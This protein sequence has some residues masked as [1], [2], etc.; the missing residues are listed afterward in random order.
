MFAIHL[1]EEFFL[2]RMYNKLP[3]IFCHGAHQG[4]D[5]LPECARYWIF[6]RWSTVWLNLFQ[7]HFHYRILSMFVC[8][9]FQSIIRKLYGSSMLEYMDIFTK[10]VFSI[11]EVP[12]NN[13]CT[14][15]QLR[16]GA[17]SQTKD[18][19]KTGTNIH[20]SCTFGWSPNHWGIGILCHFPYFFKYASN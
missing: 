16:T 2:H 4:N 8:E 6:L 13:F 18:L 17:C 11:Y 15:K 12:V 14:D 10:E 20:L 19:H 5:L 1:R 9:V 7:V 3:F